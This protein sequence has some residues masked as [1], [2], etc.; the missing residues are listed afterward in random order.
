M[1]HN[2]LKADI[3]FDGQ[4]GLCHRSVQW[5]LKREARPYYR[6]IS[7]SHP[8]AID[9][10]SQ[11]RKQNG[12]APDPT[13]TLILSEEGT[14]STQSDAALS[15]AQHL[16][17]PWKLL[18]IGKLIPKLIRNWIYRLIAKNRYR[19]GSPEQCNI[20]TPELRKRILS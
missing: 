15:I 11:Y 13:Q 6:F 20:L 8:I 10:L 16:K 14:L 3:I 17:W 2:Q 4:C 5:I 9:I 12:D 19:L 7:S 1:E 18:V